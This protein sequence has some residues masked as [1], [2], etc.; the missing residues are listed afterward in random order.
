MG[1]GLRDPLG[2]AELFVSELDIGCREVEEGPGAVSG[3]ELGEDSVEDGCAAVDV[4][5]ALSDGLAE[6]GEVVAEVSRSKDHRGAAGTASRGAY[7]T[8]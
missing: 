7:C 1:G 3:F 8:Y 5:L 6:E 4:G 2:A